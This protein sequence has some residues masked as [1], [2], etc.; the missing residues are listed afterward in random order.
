M[1]KKMDGIWCCKTGYLTQNMLVN[2]TL[3]YVFTYLDQIS[4]LV[5]Q[6][7][8][9]LHI[10]L[11]T[12]ER[13]ANLERVFE[14]LCSQ[15]H[16]DIHLHLL[17][18]NTDT[19]LHKGV[20]E[21]IDQFRDKLCI[22]LHRPL[23]NTHCIGRVLLIKE[24]LSEY[25]MESVVIFDDDQLFD[26]D[27]LAMFMR[28]R[29]PMSTL[30]WYGKIY[31]ECDYWKSD[32]TYTDIEMLRKPDVTK[33]TYF[34]PG[35]CIFDS[36]LFLFDELYNYE[37]YSSDIYK[38]DDIWLSFV[39]SRYLNIP[40]Y[41]CFKHP[42]ECIDRNKLSKMTWAQLKDSKPK[43][44][45]MLC[46]DWGWDVVNK[47]PLCQTYNSKYST[48]YALYDTPEQYYHLKLLLSTHHINAHFTRSN[49]I[50]EIGGSEKIIDITTEIT[51]ENMYGINYGTYRPDIFD[52][53]RYLRDNRPMYRWYKK[54]YNQVTSAHACTHF[55]TKG[56]HNGNPAYILNTNEPYIYNFDWE[57]YVKYTPDICMPNDSNVDVL[58]KFAFC[59]FCLHNA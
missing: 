17:D 50:D 34:G 43:L 15:T 56:R 21:V 25:V 38:I 5:K 58:E 20:D 9:I 18:N 2:P 26:I 4:D 53:K 37:Q 3:Q 29:K 16:Q 14:M 12:Y 52:W 23:Q 10:V 22:T 44:M 28:D 24:L 54:R 49:I 36:R 42:S 19:E 51:K 6:V 7:P 46:N 8:E 30:S 27:W 11:A 47:Q 31:S 57:K 39:F 1:W 32:L 55:I 45:K 13:N 48:I 41:R 59:D 33:F 40:F 35:G